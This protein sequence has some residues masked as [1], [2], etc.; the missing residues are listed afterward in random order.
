MFML[1]GNHL[2]LSLGGTLFRIVL[3][4]QMHFFIA[5]EGTV[6]VEGSC[7]GKTF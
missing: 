2:F 4:T 1:T 5:H 7:M 3:P 6:Q